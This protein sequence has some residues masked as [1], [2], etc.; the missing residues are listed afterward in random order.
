MRLGVFFVI[1][2]GLV[3]SLPGCNFERQESIKIANKGVQSLNE[4]DFEVALGFLKKALLKDPTNATAANLMGQIY[5]HDLRNHEEA[6][7]AF[8]LALDSKS[9][10]LDTLYR[11]GWLHVETEKFPEAQL[12]L[13]S[14][15]DLDPEHGHCHYFIGRIFEA[16]NDLEG[17][18]RSYRQSIRLEPRSA[19][20]FNS[21]ADL[22]IRV[23][24]ISEAIEVL[25]EAIRLN[26]DHAE[27]RQKLGSLL[28]QRGD[29]S[30]AAQ[31]FLDAAQLS[32]QEHELLFAVGSA[33]VQSQETKAAAHFLARYLAKP[34]DGRKV[35]RPNEN[36]ARVMLENLRRGPRLMAPVGE[37]PENE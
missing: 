31:L 8:L 5:F 12:Y 33:Y 30:R 22:Y 35:D 13:Q 23:R 6:K 32:P 3:M 29:P 27:S 16:R 34:Q 25:E 11:M 28:L 9:D 1:Y 2:C 17:A 20:S 21:L 15:I 10:H 37:N 14:C 19:R 7:K 4:G 26:P 36:V 18:N 24:G